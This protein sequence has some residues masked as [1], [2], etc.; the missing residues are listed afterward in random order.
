MSGTKRM[1]ARQE[2]QEQTALNI[3]VQA[4]A[5]C[6][7]EAHEMCY[8]DGQEPVEDAYKLA[9][10]LFTNGE[11]D[12]DSRREMTDMIQRLYNELS[13]NDECVWCAEIIEK[14]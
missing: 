11:V 3:L 10:A 4:G 9:N 6:R 7:C 1:I 13:I 14:D 5:L 2:E 8:Y 12:F